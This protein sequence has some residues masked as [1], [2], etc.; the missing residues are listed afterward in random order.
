MFFCS[1]TPGCSIHKIANPSSSAGV[2]DRI[3]IVDDPEPAVIH[4]SNGVSVRAVGRLLQLWQ[5][6]GKTSDGPRANIR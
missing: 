1:G 2:N 6:R 5:Q 4:D 3:L